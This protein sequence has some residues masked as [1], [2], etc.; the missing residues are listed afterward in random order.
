M[1]LATESRIE[2]A[3]WLR[4]TAGLLES[5]DWHISHAGDTSSLTMAGF[6]RT[7]DQTETTMKQSLLGTLCASVTWAI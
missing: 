4:E 2:A 7:L 1:Y 3:V 5:G 6:S